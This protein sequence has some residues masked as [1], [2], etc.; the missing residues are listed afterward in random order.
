[1]KQDK[2]QV[3]EIQGVRTLKVPTLKMCLLELHNPY[4]EAYRQRAVRPVHTGLNFVLDTVAAFAIWILNMLTIETV[5]VVANAAGAAVFFAEEKQD[6]A[7]KLDFSFLAFAIIFPLSFLLQSTFNRREQALSWF[8]DFKTSVLSGALMTLTVDWPNKEGDPSNGRLQL[9]QSFNTQVVRDYRGL[10]KLVYEYLSMPRVS[11]AR[12]HIFWNKQRDT[13]KVHSRQNAIVQEMNDC[14]Y[15]FS[16]QTEE[17]KSYGFPSG[18]ASRLHQYRQF[19]QQRF[20]H[21]RSFKYYRTPQATRSFGRVYTLLLPW[22]MGP[23]WAWVA[24]TT[25]TAYATLL[26]AFT[27]V[28]LLGL[29]NVQQGLEDPFVSD[30][31]SWMPGIDTIKFDFEM[32]SMIQAIEQYSAN[33]ELQRALLT[34]KKQQSVRKIPREDLIDKSGSTPPA[35]ASV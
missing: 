24:E 19:M 2:E 29:L 33:A 15:D 1:M 26:A 8:A 7:L 18:E 21:L 22:M 11:H 3:L 6:W 9:P 5:L 13:K 23:Y 14:M 35:P 16:L 20:E 31:Q 32:A 27:L 17:M 4:A 30:Y 12:N 10:I 34:Q 25:S 28:V